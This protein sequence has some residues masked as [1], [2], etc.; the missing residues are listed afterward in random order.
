[1]GTTFDKNVLALRLINMVT[2]SAAIT[3]RAL[4]RVKKGDI[5]MAVTSPPST[6]FIAKLVCI[7]HKAHCVL[8][9][10]DVYPE[11]LVATGII[12]KE[13]LFNR[14]LEWLNRLLYKS[15]DC[16][17]V[18][19]RDMKALAEKKVGNFNGNVHI[20]R[21]WSDVDVVYP[22]TRENNV[23]LRELNFQDKFVVSC[24]GNIGRAQAIESILEAATALRADGRVHFLFVGSGARKPGWSDRSKSGALRIS[25]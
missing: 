10:E 11:T 18:L 1:M 2:F 9:I 6:P 23:L 19:G 22:E 21:S 24:V 15:A 13:S 12:K 25:Q 14:G 17:V 20:I 4:M 16:I 7:L 3:A 8:R 5:V